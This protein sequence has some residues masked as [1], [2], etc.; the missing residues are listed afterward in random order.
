MSFNCKN[1]SGLKSLTLADSE[2]ITVRMPL[3]LKVQ[4][5]IKWKLHLNSNK[6]EG[7]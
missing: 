7:C 6:Y 2:V 1:D 4:T 3:S 5:S